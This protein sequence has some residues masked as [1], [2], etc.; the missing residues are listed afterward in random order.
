MFRNLVEKSSESGLKVNIQKC[1][2]WGTLHSKKYGKV[3]VCSFPFDR[4][5]VDAPPCT[6][7]RRHRAYAIPEGPKPEVGNLFS[8]MYLSW[9]S[10]TDDVLGLFC[11]SS[12]GGRHR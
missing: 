9:S 5:P 12:C 6:T 7:P 1:K 10:E 3:A 11:F 2:Q 4:T 8:A